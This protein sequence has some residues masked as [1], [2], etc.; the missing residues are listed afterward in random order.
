MLLTSTLGYAQQQSKVRAALDVGTGF[1]RTQG[2]PSV[3]YSEEVS[4]HRAPWL[5]LGLGLRAWGFYGGE[6]TLL[7][8]RSS[9]PKDTL[10]YRRQSAQGLS[11]MAGASLRL[12]PIDLGLHTDLVGVSWGRK[13]DAFYQKS[14]PTPGEGAAY[15]Q[16]LVPSRPVMLS[17]LPLAW[18]GSSGQSEIYAR[19]WVSRAVGVKV[20][21]LYGRQAYRTKVPLDNWQRNF[22]TTYALPYLAVSFALSDR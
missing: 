3:A 19:L 22:S 1:S 21:Y 15:Y 6:V 11:L 16:G 12:G 17:T 20:A 2:V 4:M 18:P 10:Y 7:S 13:R 5:H 8:A 9:T 14:T